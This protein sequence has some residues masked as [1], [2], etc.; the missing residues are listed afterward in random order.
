MIKQMEWPKKDS[1]AD[2]IEK[3]KAQRGNA[4]EEKR[5][6]KRVLSKI[7]KIVKNQKSTPAAGLLD[8]ATASSSAP[9]LNNNFMADLKNLSMF[10]KGSEE[11]SSGLRPE[12]DSHARRALISSFIHPITGRKRNRDTSEFGVDGSQPDPVRKKLKSQEAELNP[13]LLTL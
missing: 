6:D 4:L 2:A 5:I 3:R 1:L 10:H 13:P 8:D 9:I 7:L 12:A 11:K